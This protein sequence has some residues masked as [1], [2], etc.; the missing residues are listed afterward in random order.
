MRKS[1]G[2][3]ANRS[4]EAPGGKKKSDELGARGMQDSD[5]IA[6]SNTQTKKRA[7]HFFSEPVEVAKGPLI[8]V[9]VNQSELLGCIAG[10]VVERAKGHV[11][12]N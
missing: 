2:K 4:S 6:F 10:G 7:S 5:K 8:S 11:R 3:R 1:Q 12:K 9:F